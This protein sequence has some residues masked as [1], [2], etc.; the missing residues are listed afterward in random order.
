MELRANLQEPRPGDTAFHLKGVSLAIRDIREIGIKLRMADLP[1]EGGRMT[2]EVQKTRRSRKSTRKVEI[3]TLDWHEGE[4]H[5]I[6]AAGH[7]LV[8]GTLEKPVPRPWQKTLRTC[9]NL[10]RVVATRR[11]G[12]LESQQ[13]DMMTVFV[14]QLSQLTHIP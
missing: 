8:K 14:C 11:R 13:G 6:S 12:R 9:E 7:G 3:R 10:D 5:V 2:E 1:K 4:R